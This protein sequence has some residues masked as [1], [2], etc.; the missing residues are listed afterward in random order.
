MHITHAKQEPARVLGRVKVPLAD[1]AAAGRLRARWPLQG[2]P[3]GQL[4]LVCEWIDAGL[5]E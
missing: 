3:Q 2:A 1:V 4:E 5:V